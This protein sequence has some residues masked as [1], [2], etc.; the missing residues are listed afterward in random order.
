VDDFNY[1][2]MP[3]SHVL[4]GLPH[5]P[6]GGYEPETVDTGRRWFGGSDLHCTCEW[7][8]E[9]MMLCC[10]HVLSVLFCLT[11]FI[12]PHR[13]RLLSP[14]QFDGFWTGHYARTVAAEAARID[15]PI[16]QALFI[17]RRNALSSH[18]DPAIRFG[19]PERTSM[20]PQEGPTPAT[21]GT[22]APSFPPSMEID[23][24]S[25]SDDEVSGK[26]T[27]SG[28]IASVFR[29]LT[30]F[31]PATCEGECAGWPEHST[32]HAKV[33]FL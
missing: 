15:L 9:Q 11:R 21:Q 19:Y 2:L 7:P 13:I 26:L 28:L 3:S 32:S 5:L 31:S 22:A 20:P 25:E 27:S 6:A 30:F 17:G 24:G 29:V 23:C 14:L 4:D 16:N 8:Q 12:A 1:F 10:R 33:V 18:L